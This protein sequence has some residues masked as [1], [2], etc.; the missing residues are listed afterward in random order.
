[1]TTRTDRPALVCRK[2]GVGGTL[3]APSVPTGGPSLGQRA[4]PKL[5]KGT[6]CPLDQLRCFFERVAKHVS[7]EGELLGPAR[8]RRRESH[9]RIAAI[10]GPADQTGVEELGGEEP[11]QQTIALGIV[12]GLA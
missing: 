6:G 12:K 2:P 11:S 9:D 3:F 8:K 5:R 10:V 4:A 7:D 1:M